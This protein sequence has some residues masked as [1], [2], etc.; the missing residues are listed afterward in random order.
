MKGSWHYS[1]LMAFIALPCCTEVI[2][3]VFMVVSPTPTSWGVVILFVRPLSIDLYCKGDPTRSLSSSWHS[4]PSHRGTKHLPQKSRIHGGAG[5][6]VFIGVGM[7]DLKGEQSRISIL[8]WTH[9]LTSTNKQQKQTFC[10]YICTSYIINCFTIYY[11][12]C[13]SRNDLLQ[14]NKTHKQKKTKQYTIYKKKQNH[15]C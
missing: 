13:A 3:N 14:T 4:S 12:K 11:K 2:I 1:F 8:A 7:Q 9:K 6:C 15:L 10:A 5:F